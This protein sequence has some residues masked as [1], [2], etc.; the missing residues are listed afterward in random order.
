MS[1]NAAARLVAADHPVSAETIRRG[2][3]GIRYGDRERRDLHSRVAHLESEVSELR[4]LVEELRKQFGRKHTTILIRPD[5]RSITV[6]QAKQ[7]RHKYR[8]GS[9]IAQLS[10]EFGVTQSVVSNVLK[11]KYYQDAIDIGEARNVFRGR[12]PALTPEQHAQLVQLRNSGARIDD[13]AKRYSVSTG[14][15]WN[16]LR[17]AGS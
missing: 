13:L 11:G 15:V 6:E 12:R 10:V 16:Y 4:E 5:R 7:I 3:V 14:T 9:T 8:S 1:A 17:R 2:L